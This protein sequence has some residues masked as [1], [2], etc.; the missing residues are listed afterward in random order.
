MSARITLATA[1]TPGAVAIIQIRGD[2]SA[3]MLRQITGVTDWPLTCVR[4]VHFKDIDAGLAVMLSKDWAQLM[5][6]GGPRVVQ[7]IIEALIGCGA[8]YEAESPALQTYPEAASDIE[9]DMLATIARAASPAANDLLL[10]QPAR[11]QALLSEGGDLSSNLA[12]MR[13]GSSTLKHLIDPPTVVVI[14]QPNVGKSTLTNRML[15]R[16]ASIVADLPGTTRDWVAGLAEIG[17]HARSS[18]SRGVPPQSSSGR[19]DAA[20]SAIAVRWMDTPG[21]RHSDD[22]IEQRAIGLANQV[23]AAADVLIVMRDPLIGWPPEITLPRT[24]DIWVMNKSDRMPAPPAEDQQSFDT[25]PECPLPISAES[26]ANVDRL[27]AA[28]LRTIGLLNL[29]TGPVAFSAGLRDLVERGDLQGLR[30]YC[31]L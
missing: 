20:H 4:F 30:K 26:G 11:W 21:L 27:E 2:E 25:T 31:G 23:I 16:A 28:V 14:G 7:K 24:P 12:A 15:G 8:A 13:E 17:G 5:P 29:P 22:D 9:A 6:H 19:M 3:S 10:Q 1:A 18:A